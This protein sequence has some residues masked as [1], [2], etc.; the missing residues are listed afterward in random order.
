MDK[1]IIS[2]VKQVA[3]NLSDHDRLIKMVTDEKNVRSWS[4]I[5]F[6]AWNATSLSHGI[7]SICLLYGKLMECFPDEETWPLLA[8]QHL[9]YMVNALNETGFHGLSLFSGA[10]GAGLAVASVSNN[11]QNYKKLLATINSFIISNFDRVFNNEHKSTGINSG[12]YDVIDGLSGVLSYCSIYC[13]QEE[14]RK[15][16]I[17]GLEKLVELT[18]DININGMKVPGWYISSENQTSRTESILYSNGNFNT[19][20]SHGISGPLALLADMKCHGF[21]VE[22]QDEAIE[23]IVNFLFDYKLYD[24]ERHFWKGQ[25]DF[26]EFADGKL[27]KNNIVRR[28]AW[29]YGNPGICYAI[30]MAGK[31]MHRPEW[32]H[33]ALD[34]IE[35]TMMNIKGIFSPTFCHGFSGLYQLLNSVESVIGTEK[36][37]SHKQSL[38]EKIMSYYDSEYL[39][40]FKNMEIG[41]DGETVK[42]YEYIGL[43]DG[44]VG[45]CLTL[46]EDKYKGNSF[47]KKAFLLA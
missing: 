6:P 41:D 39:F 5:K 4:G 25:I 15:I 37:L 23:K 45:V 35:K 9:E 43:L 18:K 47:W 7:P 13:N 12:Y 14:F 46:L 10:A 38:M 1:D 28:D 40:G 22:G 2:I 36:F 11:F 27:S 31:A 34:N 21:V 20:F 3:I 24:G 19:S 26:G 8:H 30:L 29:C 17:K 16:L 44:T 32:I 33:Y 42:P